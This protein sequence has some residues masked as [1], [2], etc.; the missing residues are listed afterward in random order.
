ML[1]MVMLAVVVL[2]AC[3]KNDSGNQT[4]NSNQKGSAPVAS[5]GG[6]SGE[7]ATTPAGYKLPIVDDGSVKLSYSGFDSWYPSASYTTELPVWK[8]IEK[9]TGVKVE[10]QVVPADQYDAKVRTQ[11][12]AGRNLPDIMIL[13]PTWSNSGVFELAQQDVIIPLDDLIDNYAPDIKALFESRPDIKKLLT[14]PDGKIYSIA[15][16]PLQTVPSPFFI[17][18]DWLTKLNLSA[19]TTLDEWVDVLTAIKNGDPNENGKADEIPLVLREGQYTYFGSAFGLQSPVQQFWANGDGHVN[20]QFILPEFKELL[21]FTHNLYKQGLIDKELNRDES[22]LNALISTNVVGASSAV[23][24]YLVQ[25]DSIL[26]SAGVTNPDTIAVKAPTGNG[27]AGNYVK[28][29][30]MWNHYGI[31]ANS[32]YPEIAMQWLNYAWISEEGNLFKD[33]GV[34]NQS[35]VIGANGPEFT[36]W[37]T[38]NPDGLDAMSALRSLGAAP[39]ILV[40]DSM[41]VFKKK[42]AGTKVETY[43]SLADNML[44]PFP[45]MIPTKEETDRTNSVMP[46]IDTYVNEMIIKFVIGKEPIENFDKFVDAVRGMG[47]EEVVKI[48]QAQY[49]RFQAE[50]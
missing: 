30:P 23:L 36:E 19:P 25:W 48:K 49:D 46:D 39:S 31:T 10:Y 35:F 40:N 18:N 50:Q 47:I 17:R 1:I 3:S 11:I 38:N 4:S 27:N 32:K 6:N 20:Y 33:Y 37:V 16:L 9:R 13:T 24:D 28:R 44:Q 5:D 8:E 22:N 34:E 29:P 42:Y 43:S 21:A 15:D 7:N 12:A 45:E 41:D 2:G 14:A 26:K